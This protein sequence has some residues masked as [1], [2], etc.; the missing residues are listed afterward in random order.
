MIN[1]TENPYPVSGIIKDVDNSTVLKD[2]IVTAYNET[3][4]EE[5]TVTSTTNS[6]GEYTLD[7]ANFPTDY[8]NGD[9]IILKATKS[10]TDK[11]K[12]YRFTI[13]TGEGSEEK[14]LT[15][16][17]YDALGLIKE[18]LSDNW[19]RGN[20][21]LKKPAF[22]KVFDIKRIDIS[23]LGNQDIIIFYEQ[24]VINTKNSIGTLTK[25]MKIPVVIDIRSTISRI[26]LLKVRNE[27][28]RLIGQ[29]IINPVEGWNIL[30]NDSGWKDLSDKSK[31]LWRFIM[32][33]EV[34]KLNM[35]RKNEYW[36]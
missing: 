23:T 31:N 16:T 15:L 20:T 6:S 9:T 18:L 5:I 13:D 10:G 24:L 8:E 4:N 25:N 2:V 1:I 21:D 17:Y 7:L 12:E 33:V 32:F 14:N 27:I 29:N 11:I 30:D 3:K 35:S 36:G 26:H 22:Y 19:E 34:E 28:D